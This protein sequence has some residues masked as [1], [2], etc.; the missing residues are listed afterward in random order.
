MRINRKKKLL[1]CHLIRKYNNALA[2]ASIGIDE[3]IVQAHGWSPNISIHGRIYHRVGPLVPEAGEKPKFAQIIV[4][5]GHL[6]K[7]AML[8]S[9]LKRRM[10]IYGKV[11]KEKYQDA[12]KEYEEVQKSITVNEATMLEL[13]RTLHKENKYYKLYN[14]L[15]E[16]KPDLIQKK[17]I[18]LQN[19]KPQNSKEHQ[20]N[21]CIP[22]AC[23]IAIFDINQYSSRPVDILV[24]IRGGGPPKRISERNKAFEGLHYVLLLPNGDDGWDYTL[25]LTTA[26]GTKKIGKR[27]HISSNMF[28]RFRMMDRD[29]PE[30]PEFNSI[31]RGGRLFQASSS[32]ISKP[33]YTQFIFLQ[34]W[35]KNIKLVQL[36]TLINSFGR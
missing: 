21:F 12:K 14:A 10:E 15:V 25:H 5:D 7:E 36:I 27:C 26:E 24:N 3:E 35:H 2:C 23:E 31:I 22:S 18:V 32:F 19:E 6:E 11:D 9:Q 4:W 30:D 34:I 13:Q 20:K 33:F 17:V 16:I 29:C 28:A 1:A 8:L